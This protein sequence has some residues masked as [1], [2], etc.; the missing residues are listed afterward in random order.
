MVSIQESCF[1][2]DRLCHAIDWS[3]HLLDGQPDL[4]INRLIVD[5][6]ALLDVFHHGRDDLDET[7]D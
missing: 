1:D 5:V 4:V 3:H 7:R 6:G 2:A